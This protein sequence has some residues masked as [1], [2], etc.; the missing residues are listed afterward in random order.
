LKS[1]TFISHTYTEIEDVKL[2]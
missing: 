2:S 1:N